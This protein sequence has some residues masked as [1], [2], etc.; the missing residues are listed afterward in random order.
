MEDLRRLDDLIS[1]QERKKTFLLLF[2]T[3][4]SEKSQ[5][6][7]QIIDE[8][9]QEQGLLAYGVNASVVKDIHPV[10]RINTVPT[11]VFFRE[12]RVS[13]YIYGLQNKEYYK[14]CI[15]KCK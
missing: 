8:L 7:Y 2:Y 12:G 3:Q 1:L 6:A 4:T 10:Y 15:A 11:V 13:E 14:R 9:A 5:A